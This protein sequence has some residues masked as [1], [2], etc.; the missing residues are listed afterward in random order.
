MKF[1]RF[2][3][4]G[5]ERPG[6]LVDDGTILDISTLVADIGPGTVGGLGEIAGRIDPSVLPRVDVSG[7]RL[8]SPVARPHKILG[9]GL[10]YVDHASEAAMDVPA[11][12]I[13]FQKATS[14]L[15]GPYD[16]ILIPPGAEK[17][18]YEVELGVVIGATARYLGSVDE[19]REVI[20]GYTIAHDVSERSHQLERSGQWTKGKSADTF[21]PLGPWLVTPDEVP[22]PG[23]LHIECRV[24]GAVRQR[25]RTSNMLFSV[26]HIIWHLSQFMTLEPGD[27]IMT[28]TPPGVALSTGEYLREGDVVELEIE[29]LGLQ[30]QVCRRT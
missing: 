17:L 14:S 9:I 4:K 20:A 13:V 28:G 8:G 3:P 10:N 6:V 30:R 24:N 21:S 27:V 23:D 2:G 29:G 22:D 18:D 12:P 16:D 19:A 11:E 7:V 1:V 5:E 26:T 15:S 25:S